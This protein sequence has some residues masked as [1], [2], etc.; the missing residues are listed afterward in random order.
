L[1]DAKI[2][3]A[4]SATAARL[5]P[6]AEIA[7]SS[8]RVEDGMPG[9]TLEVQVVPVLVET[10]TASKSGNSAAASLLPSAET[11]TTLQALVGAWVNVQFWAKTEPARKQAAVK[12]T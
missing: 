11:A 2:A 9:M 1:V 5:P 8:I 12:N 10:Q 7:T 6:L 3:E 4:S